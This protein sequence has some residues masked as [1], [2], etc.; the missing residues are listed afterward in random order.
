VTSP[1]VCPKG[2]AAAMATG[3]GRE[4]PGR[5]ESADDGSAPVP[6]EDFESFLSAVRGM[7]YGEEPADQPAD[8]PEEQP[9]QLV[10]TTSTAPADE[11]VDVQDR[12]PDD[13]SA[14]SEQVDSWLPGTWVVD[15]PAP[16]G[17]RRAARRRG[18]A[19]A[20]H[21]NKLLKAERRNARRGRKRRTATPAEPAQDEPAAAVEPAR[22]RAADQ[23]ARVPTQQQATG[24]S[25]DDTAEARGETSRTLSRRERR[26][27]RHAAARARTVTAR[28]DADPDASD[29]LVESV[30]APRSRVRGDRRAGARE[31]RRRGELTG[32]AAAGG[33]EYRENGAV[34]GPMSE[35]DSMSQ[36]DSDAGPAAKRRS[37]RSGRPHDGAGT[38]VEVSAPESPV[39]LAVA[40]EAAI[41]E[42]E[43]P[44]PAD[45]EPA[46]AE[47]VG[48][49][50]P[51]VRPTRAERRRQRALEKRQLR[52]ERLIARV[53]ARA[54]ADEAK[55]QRRHE[56]R[57]RRLET[58]IA[59]AEARTA[60][61]LAALERR[62]EKRAGRLDVRAAS[63]DPAPTGESLE[64]YLGRVEAPLLSR[65]NRPQLPL[66]VRNAVSVAAVVVLIAGAAVVPW[67]APRV[68]D[69]IADALSGNDGAGQVVEDPPVAPPTD[70]FAGPVGVEASG[71][72]FDGV[73]L[74]S[75][76][77]PRQ[78]VVPRLHV[79][80]D[81][82]PISGQSGSLL[83]PDDPQV[84]GWW[85][86]GQPVGA[87]YGTAVVTG[88]TVHTGGGALDHLGK[89]VVGDKVQV[90]TD[91]GWITYVVQRTH[92]YSTEEL[93][94]DAEH[95]FRLGGTGRL[96][97]IT[98]DDFNGTFYES[99]AVVFASPVTDD[100]FV[101]EGV[102]D[103]P[104]GGPTGTP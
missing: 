35:T 33:A 104:D 77:W 48:I 51:A 4:P 90:R 12:V 58:Q 76:G 60:E 49:E 68:P 37:P 30:G 64:E 1:L 47:D 2:A 39:E 14:G 40:A 44:E 34:S 6:S 57:A 13:I 54:T 73:R 23:V 55:V 42:P 29:E 3:P 11:S 99:N 69:L 5:D 67:A 56:K 88:H 71:G 22:G 19:L 97:L 21:E 10:A 9:D 103:V 87:Q 16:R 53:N 62:Q 65:R 41:P 15:E 75:A 24:A 61:E 38:P 27:E 102:G 80:S 20:A 92:V 79:D 32:S 36:L 43:K 63:G 84:L 100:P 96:V 17:G 83:P 91:D 46:R 85:R 81:V 8:Q 45:P 74:A 28:G 86:E 101:G 59:R 78:V 93:A 26:E 25:G 70:A 89:L 52:D 72:P 94:R 98:C 66:R 18:D 82:I 50:E 31:R 7:V 95:I